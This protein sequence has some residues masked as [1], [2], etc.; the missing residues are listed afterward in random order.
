MKGMKTEKKLLQKM[1]PSDSA[2][3]SADHRLRNIFIGA[4]ETY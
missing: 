1:L 4:I 3:P 2:S